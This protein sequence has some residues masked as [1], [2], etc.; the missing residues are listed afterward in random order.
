MIFS[1][2]RLSKNSHNSY[3]AKMEHLRMFEK[4]SSQNNVSVK[5]ATT[6]KKPQPSHN[7]RN[8]W[9]HFFPIRAETHS[10]IHQLINQWEQS[11]LKHFVKK[12]LTITD[13]WTELIL[14]FVKL[15]RFKGILS[16]RL[17]KGTWTNSFINQWTIKTETHCQKM[18]DNY[19]TKIDP[20]ICQLRDSKEF[21]Q[22]K[23]MNMNKF[24]SWDLKP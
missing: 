23:N 11:K 22:I 6:I 7:H 24:I 4:W 14:R 13:P 12:L 10:F 3:K 20:D 16:V 18:T 15:N 2:H 19:W 8:E 9:S 17:K 5:T 1:K 21:Y